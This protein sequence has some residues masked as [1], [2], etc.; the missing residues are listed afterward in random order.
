MPLLQ[1]VFL[2][3]SDGVC[4]AGALGLYTMALI[5]VIALPI[6][7]AFSGIVLYCGWFR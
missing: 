3:N 5:D 6:G 2:K 7:G 1:A 4:Q